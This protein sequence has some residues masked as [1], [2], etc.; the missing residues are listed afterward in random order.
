MSRSRS[1]STLIFIG[2][3]LCVCGVGYGQLPSSAVGDESGE[4]VVS[5]VGRFVLH[6]RMSEA[7]VKE[8]G[9]RLERARLAVVGLVRS[10]GMRA[11]D[12][13]K[14]LAVHFVDTEAEFRKTLRLWG[15]QTKKQF[16]GYDRAENRVVV[17]SPM[18]VEA[19]MKNWLEKEA[20]AEA[21]ARTIFH[22]EVA[23]QVTANLGLFELGDRWPKWL[24]EGWA[25]LF[26]TALP[27]SDASKPPANEFR[28]L[29]WV[30]VLQCG[31]AGEG[32]VT[33]EAAMREIRARNLVS[34]RELVEDDAAFSDSGRG[35]KAYSASWG[36][37]RYLVVHRPAAFAAFVGAV[38]VEMDGEA[39]LALFRR[40]FVVTDDEAFERA[41]VSMMVADAALVKQAD[42]E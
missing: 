3:V 41:W 21:F 11:D 40:V 10:L 24:E 12:D 2:A 22:H 26:E 8:M 20:T 6:H 1:I 5:E 27:W 34:W 42:W 35:Y 23:H 15:V 13:A 28:L 17:I 14:G 31:E 30:M 37:V 33:V 39:R 19:G 36:L 29:D 38:D 32:G 16:G 4:V 9:E 7:Q 18:L 25:G